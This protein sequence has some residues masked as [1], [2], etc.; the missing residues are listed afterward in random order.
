V[1][2]RSG[3]RLP[4]NQEFDTTSPQLRDAPKLRPSSATPGRTTIPS[5]DSDRI[6]QEDSGRFDHC[7]SVWTD[8][9]D[10]LEKPMS[11]PQLVDEHERIAPVSVARFK[12]NCA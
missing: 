4:H 2:W 5:H 8:E 11:A 9:H 12:V 3:R 1:A 6:P 10:T 7:K